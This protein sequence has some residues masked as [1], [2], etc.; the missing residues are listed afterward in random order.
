MGTQL[1]SAPYTATQREVKVE[2]KLWRVVQREL[3]SLGLSPELSEKDQG[4]PVVLTQE[5]E[6]NASV[7]PSDLN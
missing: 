7:V 2:K 5:L 6:L 4:P 1:S 3:P